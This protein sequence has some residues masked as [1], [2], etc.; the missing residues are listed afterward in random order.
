MHIITGTGSRSLATDQLKFSKIYDTL[1]NL[2]EEFKLNNPEQDLQILA[3]GAEGFDH[4]LAR[5]A[6]KCS[7]PYVLAL[8]NQGYGLHYWGKASQTRT[9]RIEVF[10][11]MVDNAHEVVYVCPS[12]YGEDGRHS[13]FIRNEYMVD[14]S[15]EVWVYNP[16]TPGTRQCY[17]Y[18]KTHGKL[19]TIIN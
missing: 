1:V 5:A 15:N 18:A 9:N 19:C 8:P 14:K 17:S 3:G 10:N 4:A 12:I 13:N 11:A 2:I 7:V 16:V 6:F